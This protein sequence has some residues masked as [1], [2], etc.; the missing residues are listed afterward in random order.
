[1]NQPAE[2]SDP[3]LRAELDELRAEVAALR[4]EIQRAADAPAVALDRAF[5]RR[6]ILGLRRFGT[7]LYFI[8]VPIYAPV[9]LARGL[10]WPK[11]HYTR[12]ENLYAASFA[13]VYLKGKEAHLLPR[14][15]QFFPEFLRI[16]DELRQA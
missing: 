15:F 5:G 7:L 10:I 4:A 12:W 8:L 11:R 3:E 16:R 2:D 13:W 1:M 14:L 9:S 6:S